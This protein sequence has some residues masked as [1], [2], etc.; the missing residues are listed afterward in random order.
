MKKLASTLITLTCLVGFNLG[1]MAIENPEVVVTVP[2]DFVAGGKT[3]PAGKYTVSRVSFNR[4]GGLVISSYEKGESAIVMANQ[5][6]DRA[7]DNTKVSFDKVGDKLFLNSIETRDGVYTV[8][9]PRLSNVVAGTKQPEG[10]S[11]SG[12]N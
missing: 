9:L 1:A 3:L 6:E 2:F 8:P 7:S 12:S 4:L 11:A 5:F 10:M